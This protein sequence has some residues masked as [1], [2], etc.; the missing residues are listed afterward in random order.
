ME[1]VVLFDPIIETYMLDPLG[2]VANQVRLRAQVGVE[3]AQAE[4]RKI[5]HRMPF[6]VAQN[7]RYEMDGPV[8]T[9]GIDISHKSS[10]PRKTGES[11]D[12][13]EK[14]L[15]LKARNEGSWLQK[16]LDAIEAI[17]V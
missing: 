13:P 16:A 4:V 1:S 5:M 17:R 14:Y 12:T 10:R 3:A 6:D 2:P 8:A 15:D 11:P 7:V 9:I